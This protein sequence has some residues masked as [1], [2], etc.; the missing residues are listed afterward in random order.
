[1]KDSF[2]NHLGDDEH[3]ADPVICIAEFLNHLGDDELIYQYGQSAWSFL[4]HLGDDEHNPAIFC[5]I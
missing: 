4:N 1:M 2:L 3:L 5:F